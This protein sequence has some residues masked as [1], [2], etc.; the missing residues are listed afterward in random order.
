MAA[1]KKYLI[2]ERDSQDPNRVNVLLPPDI[3][4]QLRVMAVLASFR[5]QFPASA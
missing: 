1:F 2:V 3:V 5:L 4:N